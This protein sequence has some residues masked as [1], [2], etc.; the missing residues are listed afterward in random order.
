[1]CI[2]DSN[3]SGSGLSRSNSFQSAKRSSE[4]LTNVKIKNFIASLFERLVALSVS[5][6]ARNSGS[7]ETGRE[8]CDFG[9]GFVK[10]F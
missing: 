1:M 10:I 6:L 7:S 4:D 5:N 2:R 8:W 9:R 3:Q